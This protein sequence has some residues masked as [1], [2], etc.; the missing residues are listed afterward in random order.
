MNTRTKTIDNSDLSSSDPTYVRHLAETLVT[1]DLS[2]PDHDVLDDVVKII[3]HVSR[4]LA[5]REAQLR[6]RE[7]ALAKQEATRSLVDKLS[8]AVG[9]EKTRRWF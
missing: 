7:A 1:L 4:E 5:V 8:A 9:V 2:S 3:A 6:A